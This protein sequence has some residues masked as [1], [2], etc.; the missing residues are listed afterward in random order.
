M[1]PVCPISDE[2]DAGFAF[3]V[4]G[5]RDGVVGFARFCAVA[6]VVRT[7]ET[8]GRSNIRFI[9]FL[10]FCLREFLPETRVV[11]M[12]DSDRQ[13]VGRVMRRRNGL[14]S[15]QCLNHLAD[16]SFVGV[17]V[18]CDRLLYQSRSVLGDLDASL[19]GEKEHGASHLSEL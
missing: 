18:A 15:Q 7:R 1:M 16:L 11:K 3:F 2:R 12:A 17:A 5:G 6:A 14:E 8:S 9:V 13:G 4:M 10:T 19:F